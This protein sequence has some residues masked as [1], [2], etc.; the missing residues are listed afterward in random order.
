MSNAHVWNAE[1]PDG[2]LS[3]A[4]ADPDL[5]PALAARPW[6]PQLKV[7]IPVV[8]MHTDDEHDAPFVDFLGVDP[9]QAERVGRLRLCGLCDTDLV[10]EIAFIGPPEMTLYNLCSDPPM[11]EQCARA[12]LRYCP[13][14][15]VR[16]HR[17]APVHRLHHEVQIPEGVERTRPDSWLLG[18]A[19]GYDMALLRGMLVFQISSFTVL[20]HFTYTGHGESLVEGPWAGAWA[21][22]EE[23]SGR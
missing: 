20:K 14:L 10:A 16:H 13:H 11:H 18:I 12:A 7:P 21:G 5:P 8:N 23:V 22:R 4:G 17:P 1:H 15:R 3:G 9:Q 2:G 6:H 19:S